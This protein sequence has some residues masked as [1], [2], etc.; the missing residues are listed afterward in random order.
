MS[1]NPYFALLSR[2]WNR[3]DSVIYLGI[4]LTLVVTAFGALGQ[5]WVQDV[6]P[7]IGG[8]V[9][10]D[11]LEVL[12]KLLLISMLAEILQMVKISLAQH[13]LASEPFLIVGLISVVRRVLII[14]A[15]GTRVISSKPASYFLVLM[16]ELAIL[17]FLLFAFVWGLHRLRRQRLEES[18]K[19]RAEGREFGDAPTWSQQFSEKTL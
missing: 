10:L 14:T 6:F 13:R 5:I 11:V 15:E 4:G 12:D 16:V 7:W 17:A 3:L 2:L 1:D 18:R 19:L 8:R 9:Q